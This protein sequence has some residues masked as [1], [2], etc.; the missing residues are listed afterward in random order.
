MPKVVPPNEKP[1]AGGTVIPAG[2]LVVVNGKVVV[3]PTQQTAT[4]LLAS[5]GA[6]TITTI[7]IAARS[8]AFPDT[9]LP[10]FD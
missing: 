3:N 5:L 2:V 8:G 4:S 9:G 7:N 10:I 1:I 6:S